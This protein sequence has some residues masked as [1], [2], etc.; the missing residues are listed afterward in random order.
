VSRNQDDLNALKSSR[1]EV[2]KTLSDAI[3][4]GYVVPPRMVKETKP[5]LSKIGGKVDTETDAS[6]INQSTTDKLAR[7]DLGLPENAPITT[8]TLQGIRK[9][10]GQ[11]YEKLKGQDD[12]KIDSEYKPSNMS[13]KLDE[14]IGLDMTQNYKIKMADAVEHIKQLRA[15][16]DAIFSSAS[17]DP[18][19]L[20]D[21]RLYRKEADDLELL[22]ER[23]LEKSGNQA[24][25]RDFKKARESIAKTHLYEDAIVEGTGSI[26]ARQIGKAVQRG[27]YVTGNAKKIGKFANVFPKANKSPKEIATKDAGKL[28]L[29]LAPVSGGGLGSGVGAAIGG[30]IGAAIGGGIGTAASLAAPSMARKNLLSAETQRSLVPEYIAK[31]NAL[32]R[33]PDLNETERARLLMM[34]P[35]DYQ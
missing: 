6:V 13:P 9:Q 24:V 18:K 20:K 26:D 30:P 27:D 5:I 21:A 15:D 32:S 12:I 1:S 35:S 3:E 4:S 25:L 29:M 7:E 14:S 19:T 2:D 34:A 31:P 33:L 11:F 16:A 28:S 8:E 17:K 22:I 23:N 10:L